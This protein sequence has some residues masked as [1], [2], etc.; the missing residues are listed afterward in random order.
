MA[1]S[2]HYTKGQPTAYSA[3]LTRLLKGKVF[4]DRLFADHFPF[5]L[6]YPT[7]QADER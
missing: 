1:S 4:L 2:L 7:C 5:C 6:Q 3:E